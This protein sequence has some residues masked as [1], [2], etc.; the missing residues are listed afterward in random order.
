LGRHTKR[1]KK[2]KSKHFTNI[3]FLANKLTYNAVVLNKASFGF[4]A[5]CRHANI[6]MKVAF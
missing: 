1:K 5:G 2:I 4:V 3:I 6:M